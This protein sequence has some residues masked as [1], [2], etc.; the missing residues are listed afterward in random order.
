MSKSQPEA[1]FEAFLKKNQWFIGLNFAAILLAIVDH[2]DFGIAIGI[3]IFSR[4][5]PEAVVTFMV[6]FPLLMTVLQAFRS[7]G[8]TRRTTELSLRPFLRLEYS[9]YK[10]EGYISSVM[11]EIKS[12]IGY[13]QILLVNEGS[14]VAVDV[15]FEPIII[16]S[17]EGS[18]E[19][20]TVTA[21]SSKGGSTRLLDGKGAPDVLRILD[22]AYSTTPYTVKVKYKNIEGTSY[23][24]VFK[25]S[26]EHNDGYEVVKW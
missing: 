5:H 25:S 6:G 9:R 7:I 26:Q 3:G 21:M 12:E 18:I 13:Y 23:S 19:L 14:G 15:K 20:H 16:S 2:Y 24:Q 10:A 11:G 1:G 22:P 4:S 17:S 8:E